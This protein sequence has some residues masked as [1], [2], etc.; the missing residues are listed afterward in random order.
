MPNLSRVL[1]A[2]ACLC[3]LLAAPARS[4]P[5]RIIDCADCPEMIVV[6]AGSFVMGSNVAERTREG[7]APLFGDR[8]GPQHRVAIAHPFAMGRTEVTRA[9]FLAFADETR[10][11]APRDCQT[12][13][14][15]RDSWVGSPHPSDWRDPGFLQA[16]THP[17][18]CMSWTDAAAYAAWLT[19]KTRHH[20]RLPSEAE[21]EYAARGNTA[22]ARYWG[23]AVE[24]ICGQVDMM[25][26]ALAA[27]LGNPPSWRRALVCTDT[28]AWT[29]PVGSYAP[30]PF[31]LYDMLGSLWEWT[32]DCAR[33]DYVG[34][35]DDGSAR[36]G[37]DLHPL[38]GGAFHSR[39]WLARAATRGKGMAPDFRPIAA[40]IRLVRELD[41]PGSIRAAP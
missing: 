17:I 3:G 22:T 40:G 8:E 1:L 26:A 13:D 33:P 25:T 39:T 37:C 15:A 32:A 38:R 28:P 29:L 4:A 30:N 10:R 11:P 24:P 20:Y 2:F 31:G 14:P 9:Q 35:P 5:A 12:Y 19:A 7:V 23:D 27:R 41:A 16:G 34:A 21:W 6:P 18:A 36:T